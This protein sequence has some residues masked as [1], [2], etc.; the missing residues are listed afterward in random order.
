MASPQ[1]ARHMRW[2]PI[3][4]LL[5]LLLPVRDKSERGSWCLLSTSTASHHESA[6]V[7]GGHTET[8][9]RRKAQPDGRKH[10]CRRD[11]KASHH[12]SGKSTCGERHFQVREGPERPE[13][14]RS[15]GWTERQAARPSRCDDRK[16]SNP[17]AGPN[18]MG[19]RFRRST[20]WP[21]MR[22]RRSGAPWSKPAVYGR[23]LPILPGRP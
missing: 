3:S 9:L 15:G 11:L 14:G 20:P 8:P 10:R 16:Q 19:S 6:T 13:V 1:P 5:Q 4:C 7:Y 22:R 23:D 2:C 21:L 17:Q 18:P 12:L